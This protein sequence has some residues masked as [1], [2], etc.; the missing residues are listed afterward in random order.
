MK[1][2]I[3]TILVHSKKEFT[4]RFQK[5][6]KFTKY[7]QIDF[8]DGKFVP[9]KSISLKQTPS[10]K[11]YKI[12]FEAHLMVDHPKTYLKKLAQLGFKKVI[13]HLE[14]KDN[15][16]ETINK[17][18]SLKMQPWLAINPKTPIKKTLPLTNQVKG[19]LFMGITP[20]KEHQTFLPSVYKNIAALRK[21][22]PKLKIQ[23]DGGANEKTIPKL[24]KLGV[25]YINSGSYIS[26]SENPK[27]AY[28]KLSIL[29]K[30]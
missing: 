16:Q 25:N 13:F 20:G 15:P 4:P 11:K 6:I 2:I 21:Q 5:L 17:I 7:I 23:V 22:K 10:L 3:P 8:M 12:S 30:K 1:R 24:S 29:L 28:K 9:A 18:K 27:Q 26:S 19:I 14:S